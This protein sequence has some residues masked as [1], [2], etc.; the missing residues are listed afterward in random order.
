MTRH[1]TGMRGPATLA[2]LALLA[3]TAAPAAAAAGAPGYRTASGSKPVKGAE[4]AARRPRDSTE[5]S[6]WTP[7]DGGRPSATR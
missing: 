2:A 4:S 6:T 3:L 7:S 5:G 1:A